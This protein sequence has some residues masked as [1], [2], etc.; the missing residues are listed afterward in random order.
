GV[1]RLYGEAGL[2]HSMVFSP[3][4]PT[5]DG[6]FQE[7]DWSRVRAGVGFKVFSFL[8]LTGGLTYNVAVHQDTDLPIMTSGNGLPFFETHGNVS[9]WPG[10]YVG[11]RLGK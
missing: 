11:L 5:I 6:D 9:L 3:E 10:A 8:T 7:N 4:H 1:P 2:F